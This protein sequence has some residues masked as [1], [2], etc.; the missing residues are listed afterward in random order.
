MEKAYGLALR[1]EAKRTTALRERITRDYME[2][3][4]M[5]GIQK[6]NKVDDMCTAFD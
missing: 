5:P 1:A 6:G 3:C 2:F 4:L